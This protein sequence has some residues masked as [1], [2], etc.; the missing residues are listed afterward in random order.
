MLRPAAFSA[1]KCQ[2]GVVRL[3]L[4]RWWHFQLSTLFPYVGVFFDP[5]TISKPC[6]LRKVLWRVQTCHISISTLQIGIAGSTAP[7]DHPDPL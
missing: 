2:H 6:D 4:N 7:S 1:D 3:S 5:Y